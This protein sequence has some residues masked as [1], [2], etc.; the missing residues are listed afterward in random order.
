MV[1]LMLN[2]KLNLQMRNDPLQ[3]IFVSPLSPSG[4]HRTH[5]QE[6]TFYISKLDFLVNMGVCTRSFDIDSREVDVE[7]VTV[8]N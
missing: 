8:I 6:Q 2:E 3:K 1:A 4:T 5:T 7:S